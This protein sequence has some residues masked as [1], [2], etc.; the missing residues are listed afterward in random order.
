MQ[1]DPRW[2]DVYAQV[3][4]HKQS[5]DE[6]ENDLFSGFIEFCIEVRYRG[7]RLGCR[8]LEDPSFIADCNIDMYSVILDQMVQDID[9]HLD[10]KDKLS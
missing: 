6:L 2:E 4:T 7:E 9:Y 3:R 5:T 10:R 1:R 8:I